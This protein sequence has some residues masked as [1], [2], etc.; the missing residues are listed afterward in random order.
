MKLALLLMTTL[1]AWG[2]SSDAD[3][4][5]S[6]SG[7]VRDSVTHMPVKKA[8][9]M[10][11]FSGFARGAM[12]VSASQF[13]SLRNAMQQQS[14][15]TDATGTFNIASLMPGS[16]RVTV[17]HQGYP[18]ARYGGV[19][20]T[21]EVKAGEAAPPITV[22]LIPGAIVAGRVLDEEGEPVQN[23]MVQ[24]A[25]PKTQEQ[26]FFS[27][28]PTTNEDGEY[29]LHSIPPGQYIAS[30]TCRGTV[31][32]PRPFSAGADPPP[33]RAY[34]AQYYPL[35]TDAK[36]AQVLELA[37]GT[38]KSGIDFRVTTAAVTQVRGAFN[39]GGAD[40]HGHPVQV[41]LLPADS[42]Q[43]IWGGLGSRFDQ[44][45]GTFEFPQVFP[46]SYYLYV[47]SQEDADKRIGAMQRIEVADR[48]VE[49]ALDLHR[50]IEIS[51]KI[52]IEPPKN[53]PNPPPNVS[54]N[55]PPNGRVGV[56][57]NLNQGP[58]NIMVSLMSANPQIFMQPTQ[59]TS[60]ADGSFTFKGVIPGFWKLQVN[61]GRAFLKS[62]FLDSTDVTNSPIDLTSGSAGSLRLLMS[63]NTASIRGTGPA[64][65]MVVAQRVD[66]PF[67]GGSGGMIGPTGQLQIDNLAPGKYKLIV[68]DMGGPI[69]D[70]D[71]QE[72]TVKEGET[73]TIELKAPSVQ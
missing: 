5:G 65:K 7:T 45:K 22:E 26:S 72:V 57:P 23:C 43:R 46:G 66:D 19:V 36:S 64:G 62:A 30:T 8:T 24:L 42:T 18:Q 31:F 20:K 10:V 69:L 15:S 41:Q 47:M 56:P 54:P 6:L 63:M 13:N 58:G 73:L 11:M 27:G 60:S 25:S 16:Y 61:M 53:A 71:G 38:E 35:A 9:V 55:G 12:P 1:L 40:W 52:E 48:P 29:R 28:N 37:P 33:S 70:A 51:G 67:R 2:Q 17:Q 44:A 59:A 39:P 49:V 50:G 68:T 4:T 34:A 14:T 3:R 21:V 32:Q